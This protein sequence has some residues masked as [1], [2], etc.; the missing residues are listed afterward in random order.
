MP[1]EPPR[2]LPSP[3]QPWLLGSRLRHVRLVS[4]LV[5]FAY[6]S[7]HLLNHGLLNVSVAAADRMLLAQKALWQGPAG[8]AL[9]YG[10]LLT[11]AGLGVWSLYARRYAGW[12]PAE[13]W[14]LVLG[15]SIPAMLANHVMV[16]RA[17]WSLHGLNKGYVAE[18]DALWVGGP[19][20]A[21][22]L[23]GWLQIGGLLVA[24]AHACIGL[25]FLLRLRRWWPAWQAPLLALAVVIPILALLGFAAGGREVA[26]AEA[27]PAWR[28]TQLPQAVAGTPD[29]KARL[30]RLR[31][32]LVAVY[33]GSIALALVARLVRSLADRRG[34]RFAIHYPGRAPIHMLGGL[35]VLDASRKERI[36]HASVCGGRGR[37]S[38]CRVR[39]L[40]SEAALPKPTASE[41]HVLDR[42]GADPDTIRLAC[43]LRP[44]AALAVVPLIPP[45]IAADFIAGRAARIPGDERFL[46]A[47]FIDLRGSTALA[48]SRLP[49]DSVFLL[50]RFIGA[51]SGAVVAAGGRPVQFLGDGAL[52]LGM[53]A[54]AWLPPGAGGGARGRCGVRGAKPAVQP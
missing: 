21:P 5:L 15:L 27:D 34:R 35:T 41:R 11:H 4:G 3:S 37:C 49:F 7:L 29:Q 45:G 12:R 16:T 32:D 42:I 38:T 31:N 2:N 20:H 47:M 1:T 9:L 24:W 53:P 48:E 26:R 30:A 50:G 52:C 22:S 10:A 40:W 6:V 39:V 44:E 18:L 23:W 19:G 33:A 28:A 17:A 25:F 51:A 13:A 43:Q 36:G 54:R 14:Q 8:T 46:V